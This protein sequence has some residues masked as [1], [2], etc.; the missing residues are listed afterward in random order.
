MRRQILGFPGGADSGF[1]AWPP[2]PETA[3]PMGHPCAPWATETQ[4]PPAVF[5]LLVH[6]ERCPLC[7]WLM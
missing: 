5:G 2:I 7:P 3:A 4:T 1:P 6:N